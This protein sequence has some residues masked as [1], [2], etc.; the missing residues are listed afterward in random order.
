MI[1]H[2]PQRPG[3]LEEKFAAVLHGIYHRSGDTA[4][5]VAVRIW[6]RKRPPLLVVMAE[7]YTAGAA[8]RLAG[9]FEARAAAWRFDWMILH[10]DG[11]A[12]HRL[13]SGR[14]QKIPRPVE[15]HRVEIPVLK[16]TSDR[17]RKR[18]VDE[19]RLVAEQRGAGRLIDHALRAARHWRLKRGSTRSTINLKHPYYKTIM[20]LHVLLSSASE[21]LIIGY[22]LEHFDVRPSELPGTALAPITSIWPQF[23]S[24]LKPEEIDAFFAA[25]LS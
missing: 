18:T 17:R 16:A 7:H 9:L 10:W 21:G 4:S 6:D 19:L 23:R 3:S 15:Y 1:Q 22:D 5:Q 20:S 11:H 12:P 24:L 13:G 8:A 25:I 2:H 14:L